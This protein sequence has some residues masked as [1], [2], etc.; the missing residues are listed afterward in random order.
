MKRLVMIAALT[1]LTTGLVASAKA[2]D[3]PETRPVVHFAV[4]R[5]TTTTSSTTTTTEAPA[6][7]T[8]T[9]PPLTFTAKCP[10]AVAVARKVG[11]PTELLERLDATVWR[12]SRCDTF[13]W[14]RDDPGSGS[15]GLMQINSYWCTKNRYNPHPAGYLGNLGVLE[16]C[17]ELFIPEVNMTAAL[18]LCWYSIQRH[19]HCWHPWKL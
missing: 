4:D 15:R 13:A 7:T 10:E 14:N 17:D 19:G 5:S 1:T 3:Q 2:P 11:W 16:S 12:E 8:T 6:P 18:H 9:L